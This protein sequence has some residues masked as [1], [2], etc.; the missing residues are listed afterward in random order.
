MF[1]PPRAIDEALTLR[2]EMGADAT[3]LSGGADMSASLNR[4][5]GGSANLLDR[6]HVDGYPDL[7]R[8]GD[9]RSVSAGVPFSRLVRG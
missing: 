6:T 7:S 2:A 3:P 1:Y 9:G 8:T 5:A 4:E